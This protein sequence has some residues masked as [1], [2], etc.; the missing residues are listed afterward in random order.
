MK[1]PDLK[2]RYALGLGDIVACTLHSKP[3]GWLVHFLT[4]KSEPCL[5]CSQRAMA[6]NF[7]FPIPVWKIFFK[8]MEERNIALIE[9]FKKSGFKMMG[10][11]GEEKTEQV[12]GFSIENVKEENLVV[13]EGP[14]I[15]KT[16]PEKTRLVTSN[17]INLEPY[18]VKIE[19]YKKI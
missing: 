13:L 3:L 14:D 8:T 17:E 18:L 10:F 16:I 1:K 5:V 15:E 2:C 11:D 4:G 19:V 9:D 7:L 12:S 6:L